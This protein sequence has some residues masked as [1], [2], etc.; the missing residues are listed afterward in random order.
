M[1]P[2]PSEPIASEPVISEPS[3]S[4]NTSSRHCTT[5]TLP[6][7]HAKAIHHVHSMRT[8]AHTLPHS[9]TPWPPHSLIVQHNDR[10]LV[11]CGQHLLHPSSVQ[12]PR[13][14]AIQGHSCGC[15]RQHMREGER[16]GMVV[17]VSEVCV[18]RVKCSNQC[19]TCL[20]L[21]NAHAH[22]HTP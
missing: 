14:G 3:G 5:L 13:R 2:I 15:E 16:G 11:A 9:L 20:C 21:S 7:R 4:S 18:Q 6:Q 17:G 8:H 10:P 12:P 19:H 22:M 1:I